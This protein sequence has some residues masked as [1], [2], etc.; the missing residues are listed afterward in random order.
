MSTV[1]RFW[2]FTAIVLGAYFFLVWKTAGNP[3]LIL[4]PFFVLLVFAAGTRRFRCPHCRNP[5]MKRP[6]AENPLGYTWRLPTGRNCP[7]C[8]M[9]W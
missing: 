2:T 3:R 5:I 4:F 9:R 6:T 1:A 7:N 8:G